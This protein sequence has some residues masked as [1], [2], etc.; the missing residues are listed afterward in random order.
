MSKLSAR[1]FFVWTLVIATLLTGAPTVATA[2]NVTYRPIADFLEN[3]PQ[4]FNL[5]GLPIT[6]TGS[7]ANVLINLGWDPHLFPTPDRTAVSTPNFAV[8]GPDPFGYPG[9]FDS[10]LSLTERTTRDIGFVRQTRLNDGGVKLEIREWVYWGAFSLYDEED[11]FGVGGFGSGGEGGCSISGGSLGTGCNDLPGGSG[12][13]TALVGQDEDGEASYYLEV[14]LTY[15]AAAV[16]LAGGDLDLGINPTI[17]FILPALA[18][19]TPGVVAASFSLTGTASGRVT[20]DPLLAAK[21]GL[22]PRKRVQFSFINS[23]SRYELHIF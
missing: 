11:I 7:D 1:I 13:P 18:G 20:S 16:T 12:E 4:S 9:G 19:A 15:T 23:P 6:G 22:R 17:P 14:D 21:F 8:F 3:N 5:F 2:G 10:I